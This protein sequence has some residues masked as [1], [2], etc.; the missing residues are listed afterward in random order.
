VCL[1]H[2]ERDKSRPEQRDAG[3]NPNRRD[4][5]EEVGDRNGKQRSGYESASRQSR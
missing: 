4:Q 3:D 2:A 1:I 5:P